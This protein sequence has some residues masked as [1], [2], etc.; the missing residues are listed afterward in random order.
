M[1]L[2]LVVLCLAAPALLFSWLQ[3]RDSFG[4]ENESPS[5]ATQQQ[6]QQQQPVVSP[7]KFMLTAVPAGPNQ[8]GDDLL[9]SKFMQKKLDASTQ[10][11]KGLMIEDFKLVEDNADALLNMSREE[12]WRA[13]NDMMY[14]QHST[15]FRN[16]VDD[17]RQKA[18]KESIDG[19]SLAW[20]NV[21]MSCIQC[22]QWVRNIMLA[23]QE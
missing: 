4:Q 2:R 22:H 8:D 9:L 1:Q 16:V 17:L 5:A 20:V 10:I 3:L 11:L 7:A 15:Q 19:A 21:T 13:S 12:K 6:P 14:L 23:E 18:G